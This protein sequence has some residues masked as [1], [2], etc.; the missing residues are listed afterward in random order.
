MVKKYTAFPK[1]VNESVFAKVVHLQICKLLHLCMHTHECS[2]HPYRANSHIVPVA[3]SLA[4]GLHMIGTYVSCATSR[5]NTYDLEDGYPSP[6]LQPFALLL[7]KRKPHNQ[8]PVLISLQNDLHIVLSF[9]HPAKFPYP[10]V[11]KNPHT[12]VLLGNQLLYN[13]TTLLN[14]TIFTDTVPYI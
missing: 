6:G 10:F 3:L 4:S 13:M 7:T 2:T 5:I 9:K 14:S 11:F 1:K 12:S 8:I